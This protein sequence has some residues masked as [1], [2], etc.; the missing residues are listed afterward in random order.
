MD[1]IA[2]LLERVARQTEIAVDAIDNAIGLINKQTATAKAI[3]KVQNEIST[4]QQAYNKYMAQANSVGLSS[5]YASQVRNGTLKIE[6][7]KDENLKTKIEDY[8][9]W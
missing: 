7:I 6:N 8:K 3:S 5:S 1:W 4:N 9:K 2:I